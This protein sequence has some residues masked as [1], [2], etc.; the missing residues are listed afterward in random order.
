MRLFIALHLPSQVQAALAQAQSSLRRELDSP[1][2]RWTRPESTHL[3]LLFLGDVAAGDVIAVAEKLRT[4]CASF[5]A[6]ELEISGAG[7]FPH[8]RRPR[9]LWLGLDGDLD[10]LYVLA[11]RVTTE[12]GIF[13]ERLANKPFHPHLTLARI[14][15]DYEIVGRRLHQTLPTLTATP[16]HWR[17]ESV[18][19]MSSDLLPSGPQYAVVQSVAL[20][21]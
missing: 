6:F 18:E 17:V 16:A 10:A 15:I 1:A 13:S 11:A 12:C 20:R 21:F 3:T 19:L 4:A 7:C 2:L 5:P 9:V 8:A 14:K